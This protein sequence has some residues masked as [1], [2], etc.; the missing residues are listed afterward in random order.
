MV[1]TKKKDVILVLK[2]IISN[3]PPM[4]IDIMA[5][6]LKIYGIISNGGPKSTT[7]LTNSGLISNNLRLR[8]VGDQGVPMLSGVY[9]KINK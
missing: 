6:E 9:T 7:C 2:P 8:W 5:D 1:I 4:P 3:N